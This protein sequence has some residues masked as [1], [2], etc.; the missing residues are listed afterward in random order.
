[1][2]LQDKFYHLSTQFLYLQ[3]MIDSKMDQEQG[4]IMRGEEEKSIIP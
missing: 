4:K 3:V 1:M 2:N